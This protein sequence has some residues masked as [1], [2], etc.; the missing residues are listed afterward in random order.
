MLPKR[1]RTTSTQSPLSGASPSTAPPPGGWQG[2]SW[3]GSR[4]SPGAAGG[5]AQCAAAAPPGTPK[6]PGW[7]APRPT[8]KGQQPRGVRPPKPAEL[9]RGGSRPARGPPSK[10]PGRL[11]EAP[12][13][14]PQ[15]HPPRSCCHPGGAQLW[16]TSGAGSLVKCP[17]GLHSRCG[18]SYPSPWAPWPQRHKRA[19]C[20]PSPAQR[21]HRHGPGRP[22]GPSWCGDPRPPPG[23]PEQLGPR[24]C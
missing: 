14:N 7:Q 5:R 2:P 23:A 24:R 4:S 9:S 12:Q 13:E 15:P 22:R 8:W 11:H 6:R 1:S 20:R 19:R 16:Q 17:L 3:Q 10:E 18:G 21:Q